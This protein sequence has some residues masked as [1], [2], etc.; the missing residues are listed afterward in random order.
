M[1]KLVILDHIDQVT[2]VCDYD[3]NVYE[4]A[5]ECIDAFSEHHG[6]ELSLTNVSF[7]EVEEFNLK[8]L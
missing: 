6:L 2:Y 4:D 1:K 8:I 3:T 5:L 7:M